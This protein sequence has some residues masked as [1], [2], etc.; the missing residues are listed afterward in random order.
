MSYSPSCESYF[1]IHKDN[2]FIKTKNLFAGKNNLE[3]VKIINL[4][5]ERRAGRYEIFSDEA[6]ERILSAHK[7][8]FIFI[9]RLG[10]ATSAGCSACDFV[11]K[12]EKCGQ[13]L[14]FH[15]KTHSLN[16][17][18][19]RTKIFLPKSCPKCG[20]YDFK[21]RGFGTE[22][23]EKEIIKI[24]KN[25]NS[26]DI[27]RIDSENNNI[28]PAS[29]KPRIII[30][31]KMALPYL[32]WADTELIIFIDIDKQINLPE[33]LASENA[34]Y[35]I[36]EILFK[37]N[38]HADVYLQTFNP[39]QLILKSLSEPDRFYRTELNSRQKLNYPPYCYL[40]RFFYGNSDNSISQTE[41]NLVYNKL[42]N[43]LTEDE[44]SIKITHPIEMS[45]KYYRNKFWYVIIAKISHKNWQNDLQK[46]NKQI[47][48]DWKIDPNPISIL[49][50]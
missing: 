24:F 21:L 35:N 6:T 38:N 46:L 49:S 22:T 32:N 37:K 20:N 27:I 48:D 11:A 39:K 12:C 13:V 31:T 34:W 8:I 7:D 43:T 9:N 18:Y 17:H 15:E 30:G 2:Y 10:S 36:Q 40:V 42:K 25:K 14:I 4:S 41:A 26:H 29:K 44:K 47:N 33:Y 50:P 1:H 23:I 5:E 16:C 28:L 19:C 45:P 3:N